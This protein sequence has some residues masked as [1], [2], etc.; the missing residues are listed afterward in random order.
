M[1]NSSLAAM[2]H[3]CSLCP[4]TTIIAFQDTNGF[5]QIGNLTTGG[6]ALTQLGP[7]LD[8]ALGTGLAMQP[9]YWSGIPDQINLYSQNSSL[10]MGLS[11][12]GGAL[13]FG[14]RQSIL[15]FAFLPCTNTRNTA[16]GWNLNVERYSPIS[17]G[18]PIAAASSYTNVSSGLETWI[19]ALSI[20][21]R[22]I[23]VSTW[24][25]EANYW[26][27]AYNVPTAMTNST[28]DQK[29][30]GAVAV[31]A[32]GSAFGVV[33]KKGQADTIESWQVA[34][35]MIDWTSGGNVDLGGIWG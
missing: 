20:S 5:V 10:K 12:W 13:P 6:W 24:S 22:G 33:K 31:T 7:A 19:E 34:D 2:Y 23:Q 25:G 17:S 4:N 16:S 18:S 15:V 29:V 8:P 26:L 9:F 1:A 14:G 30:Y 21:E 3:Q 32:M 28:S 11:K 35:D 27:Q